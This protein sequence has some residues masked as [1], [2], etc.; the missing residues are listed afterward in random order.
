MWE[1]SEK[2]YIQ[3]LEHA[4]RYVPKTAMLRVLEIFCT[5]KEGKNAKD[6]TENM[7]IAWVSIPSGGNERVSFSEYNGKRLMISGIMVG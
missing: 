5:Q 7:A 1:I 2:I 6:H 3:V 4:S